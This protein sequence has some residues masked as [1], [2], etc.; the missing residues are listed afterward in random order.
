M[1]LAQGYITEE[2]KELLEQ[3]VVDGDNVEDVGEALQT[4]VTY[5]LF[6]KH[7]IET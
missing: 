2:Q 1:P 5:Y 6:N 4:V 7:N 3:H